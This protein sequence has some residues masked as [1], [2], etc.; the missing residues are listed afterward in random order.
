MNL[1]FI[2]GEWIGADNAIDNR[3]PSDISD[4]IGSYAQANA[5][6]LDTAIEAAQSAQ[7]IWQAT[8]LEARQAALMQIG[9][10]IDG[11]GG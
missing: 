11:A 5:A 3:N 8:G 6:Q 9:Q 4:L 10:C 7:K 2:A 1:N